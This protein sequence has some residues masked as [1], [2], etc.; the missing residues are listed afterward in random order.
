MI[1]K[2][3]SI[4]E[5]GS[6]DYA[7]LTVYIQ[8]PSDDLKITKRP[9]VLLCPGGGYEY[10][11]DREAE[12]MALSFMAKGFN[13]AVLRYSCAPAVFPTALLELG[14]S[15]LT[16]REHADE[17]EVDKDAIIVEGCSAG[18]HLAANYACMWKRDFVSKALLGDTSD[19]IK[20]KLRPNGLLLCYPV[21]TSGEFAHQ[22]SFEHLLG[23]K[24]EEKKNMIEVLSSLKNYLEGSYALVIM[25]D[26]DDK[27]YAIRNGSPLIIGKSID[28]FFAASD[29][30]A[31]VKYTKNY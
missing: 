23:D 30:P 4:A 18:G 6:L 25:N 7:K 29:V 22:G 5:E 21:I 3:F 31:I 10:T 20:E 9:L 17:W 2:E 16:I 27:I 12:P 19:E 8:Q 11:S 14:R 26:E 24:Y 15:I 28:G 13:A 1:Y